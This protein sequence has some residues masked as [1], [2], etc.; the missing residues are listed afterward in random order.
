MALQFFSL[1]TRHDVIDV[2]ESIP[3]EHSKTLEARFKGFGKAVRNGQLIMIE[4]GV[5]GLSRT[6][7]DRFQGLL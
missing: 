2:F 5:F 3:G 4:D 6:E 7:L 1:L